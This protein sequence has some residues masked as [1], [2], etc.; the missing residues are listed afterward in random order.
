LL[1]NIKKVYTYIQRTIVS[2]KCQ[3]IDRTLRL[4][5]RLKVIMVV[6]MPGN[7]FS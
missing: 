6:L 2:L 5:A 1:T 4:E 3:S 7:S